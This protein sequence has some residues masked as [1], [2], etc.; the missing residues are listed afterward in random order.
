MDHLLRKPG[1]GGLRSPVSTFFPYSSLL[2]TPLV[3]KDYF[4]SLHLDS[5]KAV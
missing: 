2:F 3:E 5:D 4:V 1:S